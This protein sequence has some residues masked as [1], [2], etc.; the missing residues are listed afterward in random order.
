[1]TKWSKAALTFS[2]YCASA[3]WKG[4]SI[5]CGRRWRCWCRRGIQ[6][7]DLWYPYV[8]QGQKVSFCVT[9]DTISG[10]IVYYARVVSRGE[11]QAEPAIVQSL[12]SFEIA[13]LS[14]SATVTIR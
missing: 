7:T 2:G 12:R 9:R 6:D 11:Y 8:V 4:T 5:S 10:P 1:M 13:N 3:G 14:E